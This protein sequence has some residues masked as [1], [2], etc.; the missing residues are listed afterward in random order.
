[1]LDLFRAEW[2][3]TLT[4][5]KTTSFL[6]WVIPVGVLAFYLV[7]IFLSMFE[8]TFEAG[9]VYFGTG[10]WIADSLN[11]WNMI[12]EFPSNVFTRLLPL[13]FMAVFIAGEYGWRTWKNTAPRTER[14]K[15][16]PAKLAALVNLVMISLLLTALISAVAPAAGHR[17]HGL[18]YGPD[19]TPDRLA[20]FLLDTVRT[21]FVTLL[22]LIILAGYA[23]I[24]SLVTRSILGG[25]L[26][27][28]G[29]SML[30]SLALPLL[31]L[32]GNLIHQPELVKLYPYAPSYNLS[33]LQSWLLRGH[34]AETFTIGVPMPSAGWDFWGS[35]IILALWMLGLI[36]LALFVFQRQDL[37]E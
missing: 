10:D 1:M 36:G 4:N 13:A 20:S 2:R 27:S 11:S 17:I 21:A 16:I 8:E 3:K 5:Y 26:A 37:T 7:L 24:A 22:A 12:I 19:F 14:W 32:I 28:F 29:I 15:L 33:N 9:V 30:D 25:L 6:V 31:G 34:A 35:A 23:A 18:E